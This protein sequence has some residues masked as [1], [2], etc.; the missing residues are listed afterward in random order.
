M[1]ELPHL[2]ISASRVDDFASPRRGGGAEVPIR[3]RTEHAA[4]VQ[5][6]IDSVSQQLSDLKESNPE[7]EGTLAVQGPGIEAESSRLQDVRSG[8]F[9]VATTPE[10]VVLVATSGDLSV[11]SRKT[12]EYRTAESPSGKPR[13][14]QLIAR[15]EEIRLATVKDM[16]FGEIVDDEIVDGEVYFVELWIRNQDEIASADASMER[17]LQN[18]PESVRRLGGYR[19][20][21]RDV[22]LVAIRGE[23]L[24][25]L[26]QLT[27]VLAELHVP[28]RVQLRE[29]AGRVEYDSGLPPVDTTVVPLVTVAIHDTGLDV[30]HPLLAPV[31][32]G[33]E[34]AVPDGSPNDWNGH[35]TRM[36][37]LAVFGDLTEQLLEPKLSPAARL[38]SVDYL[39]PGEKGDVLWAERTDLSIDIADQLARDS[40]VIH[41]ISMGAPNPRE[42]EPTS[43]SVAIDRAAWNGGRGRLIVVSAGNVPPV[44]HERDYPGESLA[45]ALAQPAQAW[46][47]ITVNGFTD[48][49]ELAQE[50]VRLGASLPLAA[51]GQLS[52]FATSAPANVAPFK[53]DVVAEAG[54][55]APDG[56]N[57]NGGLVGLSL[58]TTASRVLGNGVTRTNATS[59][60]AALTTNVLARIWAAYPDFSP[61][62]IRGLLA[63]SASIPQRALTQLGDVDARRTFGHGAVS[64]ANALESRLSRPVMCFEGSLRPRRVDPEG[65][66]HRDIV[67]VKLPFPQESLDAIGEAAVR[68]DVTLSYFVEPS[69]AERRSRYAGARLRWDMQGPFESDDDF[70]SRVNALARDEDYS[71]RS[72][73]FNWTVGSD[74][75]SR[76][77]LQRDWVAAP[78]SA[79]ARETLIAVYPVLGWWDRKVTRANEDVPFSLVVS[80]DAGELDVDLYN[81]ISVA[82]SL[83][84]DVE[85]ELDD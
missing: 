70:I 46:N 22:I 4:R 36:A 21:D 3:D 12:E 33:A 77:T 1:P 55:T 23:L 32:I 65:H 11:L 6:L 28:P 30:H 2:R 71:V 26:P 82:L 24:R 42:H 51:A 17:F 66:V 49:D 29:V 76:G 44:L 25:A 63:H 14:E 35:G 59:A 84:L 48:L 15:I 41:N 39:E 18:N 72:R 19:G 13:H 7:V 43:W 47:A 8:T 40:R 45:S 31:L 37:G 58:L 53:P 10:E 61:A 54:N 67:M 75:R 60:A 78:G 38:V 68:L 81:P 56:T 69:E 74:S 83:P 16:S 57:A 27:S 52:P 73:S 34:T 5:Q 80:L 85:V 20:Q 9:V 64:V 79:F 62:T 50:D